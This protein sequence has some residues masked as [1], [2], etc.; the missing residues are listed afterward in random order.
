MYLKALQNRLFIQVFEASSA[1]SNKQKKIYIIFI[2]LESVKH[3]KNIF[4]IV[5]YL[6]WGA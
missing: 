2:L 3:F 4:K 6:N 1:S 5:I